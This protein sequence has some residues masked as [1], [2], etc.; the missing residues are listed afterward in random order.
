MYSKFYFERSLPYKPE[1]NLPRMVNNPIEESLNSVDHDHSTSN[2][3]CKILLENM[4]AV[5]CAL[6]VLQF[7][8]LI[9]WCLWDLCI[10][11]TKRSKCLSYQNL[12]EDSAL[13]SND[14]DTKSV[15]APRL[16]SVVVKY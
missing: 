5:S 13:E 12:I 6:L 10:S 16:S 4:F 8:C 7:V 2:N 11:K 15:Q 9:I 14:A 3:W 1:Y